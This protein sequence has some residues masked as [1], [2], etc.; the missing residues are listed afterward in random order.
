MDN[1]EM[2][3]LLLA[4]GADPYANRGTTNDCFEMAK[5]R[6][7]PRFYKLLLDNGKRSHNN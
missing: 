3:E 7:D 5:A 4:Y 2:V 6:N 1:F